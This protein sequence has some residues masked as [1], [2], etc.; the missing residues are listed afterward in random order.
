M[1]MAVEVFSSLS[2]EDRSRLAT[3]DVFGTYN[4]DLMRGALLADLGNAGYYARVLSLGAKYLADIRTTP[5]GDQRAAPIATVEKGFGLTYAGL[6]MPAEARC[7]RGE[8]WLA[9]ASAWNDLRYV[10][11]P[12]HTDDIEGRQQLAA[13]DRKA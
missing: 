1:E 12:Y 10:V 11:L 8:H 7:M 9:G 3:L 4:E 6:G 13:S 5:K 2:P